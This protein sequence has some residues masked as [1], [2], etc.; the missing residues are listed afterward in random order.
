MVVVETTPLSAVTVHQP[1]TWSV[2]V[3]H[4]PI[5]NMDWRPPPH[6][7]HQYIGLHVG[8]AWTKRERL[9]ASV[10]SGRLHPEFEVPL[11]PEGFTFSALFAVARVVGF[12]DL[13]YGADR[14]PFGR[15]V[16]STRGRAWVGG[17]FSDEVVEQILHSKW[18]HGPCG[19]IVRHV[20]PL[21]SPIPLG[22]KPRVWT[23]PSE[24]ALN[25]AAQVGV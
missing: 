17:Q 14:G 18:W 24:C 9:N 25:A 21:P 3:A 2:Q 5:L 10:L 7:A 15:V 8:K 11:G 1:W 16:E 4:S 6:I 19:W 13:E 20:R 22:G 23:V 12:V